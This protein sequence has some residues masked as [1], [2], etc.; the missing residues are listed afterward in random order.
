MTEPLPVLVESSLQIAW[1]FL[2]G[3]GD[4]A[5]PQQTAEFLLRNINTQ[6]LKEERRALALSNRAISAYRRRSPLQLSG[7]LGST[8][9]N[10]AVN[11][12]RAFRVPPEADHSRNVTLATI[13]SGRPSPDRP[14]R[15][16]RRTQR[17]RLTH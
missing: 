11:A 1:D 5:D 9:V 8:E 2:D 12:L 3:T 6:I 16:V 10:E 17:A 7:I 14:A 13:Y 4:I 15:A